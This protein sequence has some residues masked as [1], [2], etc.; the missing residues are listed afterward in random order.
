MVNQ[1]VK[2]TKQRQKTQISA[3]MTLSDFFF[4][5]ELEDVAPL[6]HHL[7]PVVCAGVEE[8]QDTTMVYLICLF[9]T[10]TSSRP[11]GRKHIV[12]KLLF[13]SVIGFICNSALFYYLI[14]QPHLY[15]FKLRDPLQQK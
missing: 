15:V 10:V 5:L 6:L 8:V 2:M 14:K 13:S 9:V 11:L 1:V 3:N 12:K 4:F 7:H